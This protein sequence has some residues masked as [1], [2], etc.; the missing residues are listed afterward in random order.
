VVLGKRICC[1][2]L[3]KLSLNSLLP[4]KIITPNSYLI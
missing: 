4:G 1:S 2:I 3:R